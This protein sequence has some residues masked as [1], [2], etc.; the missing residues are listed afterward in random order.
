MVSSTNF[1]LDLAN[2]IMFLSLEV[3]LQLLNHRNLPNFGQAYHKNNSS[4]SSDYRF[5]KNIKQPLKRS[6]RYSV[7]KY[8]VLRNTIYPKIKK[9][10][11]NAFQSAKVSTKRK[12]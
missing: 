3:H 1:I 6:Q 8:G 4:L 12:R 10:N 5:L 2:G 11:K 9:K 7:E